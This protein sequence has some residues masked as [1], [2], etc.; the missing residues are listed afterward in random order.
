[1]VNEYPM[2][3]RLR[4]GPL[5]MPRLKRTASRL[6]ETGAV[7]IVDKAGDVIAATASS[8]G[9]NVSVRAWPRPQA[10][11]AC[12]ARTRQ[13]QPCRAKALHNGR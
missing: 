5:A 3:K 7:F 11:C 1:M 12:G 10:R 2:M 8:P 4:Q 6:P 9:V 13:G